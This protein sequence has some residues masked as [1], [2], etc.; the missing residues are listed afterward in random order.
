MKQLAK[1][2]LGKLLLCFGLVLTLLALSQG[3]LSL[4]TKREKERAEAEL[5]SVKAEKMA[6]EKELETLRE[7][8]LEKLSTG[9]DI[10]EVE[11]RIAALERERASLMEREVSVVED[12]TAAEMKAAQEY[13]DKFR[14]LWQVGIGLATTLTGGGLL[15][16]LRNTGGV[17]A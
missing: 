3:C 9:E 16:G 11:G 10:V 2:S 8:R 5:A 14:L 7:M 6:A 12:L 17:P 13:E 15:G 1:R 4:Q